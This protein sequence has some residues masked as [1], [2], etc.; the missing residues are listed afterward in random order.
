MDVSQ[1]K[2]ARTAADRE[3]RAEDGAADWARAPSALAGVDAIDWTRRHD[4]LGGVDRVPALLG[5]VWDGADGAGA[6]AELFERL[7]PDHLICPAVCL[8]DA[9]PAAAPFLAKLAQD[10]RTPSREGVMDLLMRLVDAVDEG[11]VEACFGVWPSAWLTACG[12]ALCTT[13]P[14]VWFALLDAEPDAR[15]RR[16]VLRLLACAAPFDGGGP[17]AR[18]WRAVL[19]AHGPEHLAERVIATAYASRGDPWVW[20]EDEEEWVGRLRRWLEEGAEAA[21]GTGPERTVRLA[22]LAL[23]HVPEWLP[24]SDPDS[25]A[26]LAGLL[27]EAP[28]E[29]RP[30]GA[31]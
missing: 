28:P 18:L 26:A 5:R 14:Q 8:R 15:R 3:W 11:P 9:T 25:V 21:S 30:G 17:A 6:L 22:R 1:P 2:P 29:A 20:R 31:R 27:D 23:E 24:D 16:R 19:D 4:C 13:R 7:V 12:R 10:P